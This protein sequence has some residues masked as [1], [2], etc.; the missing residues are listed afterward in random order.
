MA[1]EI[2]PLAPPRGGFRRIAILRLSSIGDVVLTLPV[3]QALREAFPAAELHYWVKE[4]YQ[5]LVRFDPAITHVRVLERDARK[6]EDLISMSTELEDC[7]LIVDLHASLRTRV[8]TFRQKAPVLVAPTHRWLRERWVRA[9]WTRPAPTP[10]ALERYASVLAPLRL[11]VP[12]MPQ[13]H[14]G[15]EAEAW[16]ATFIAERAFAR[17]P[18]ALAPG[19]QHATKCWPEPSWVALTERASA[20]DVPMLVFST[21]GEKRALAALAQSIESNPMAVWVTEPLARA[22]ALLSH[23]VAAVTHDSGVM[24]MAAARGLHVVALFGSTSPV[25]GFA[26]WGPGH[27]VLGRELPCRPCTVH[28]R[29]ACPLG[30][31]RCMRELEV[32]TVWEAAQ[33]LLRG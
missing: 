28:G 31:F 5:D 14:A 10:H 22:A 2:A 3:V 29:E 23:S 9:K 6:L 16:A 21:A 25:L 4:E 33:E 7:D 12:Q 19:A 11:T 8:L 27:R 30:H 18:L 1:R 13:L 32:G 20:A 26:P 17:R 15:V 24:H